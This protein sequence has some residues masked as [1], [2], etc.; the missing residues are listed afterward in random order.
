MKKYR[1]AAFAAG[2]I[3]LTAGLILEYAPI[4]HGRPIPQYNAVCS[5]AMGL[6]VQG[7]A[8]AFGTSAQAQKIQS[9]CTLAT[10]TE[11]FIGPLIIL[12][13]AGLAAGLV[14]TLLDRNGLLNR[15]GTAQVNS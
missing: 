14:I 15:G 2:S 4:Y 11:H 10:T 8:H 1:I 12:G 3:A 5:G 13:I 7:I 6:F 9:A